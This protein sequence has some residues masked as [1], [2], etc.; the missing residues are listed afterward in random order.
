VLPRI[1]R[2]D[3]FK[4]GLKWTGYI[5]TDEQLKD[6]KEQEANFMLRREEKEHKVEVVFTLTDITK[7]RCIVCKQGMFETEPLEIKEKFLDDLNMT[8]GV[9]LNKYTTPTK[10]QYIA[11]W[12]I[13]KGIVNSCRRCTEIA[14][15]RM[16]SGKYN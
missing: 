8:V 16:N 5:A 6:Y 10:E 13:C 11:E 4:L 12:N 2:W 14:Q 15:K 1:Y 7:F 9:L 3:I